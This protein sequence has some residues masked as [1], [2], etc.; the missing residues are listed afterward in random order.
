MGVDLQRYGLDAVSRGYNTYGEAQQYNAARRRG[1]IMKGI[2]LPVSLA[3]GAAAAPSIGS[4]WGGASAAASSAPAAT[5]GGTVAGQGFSIGRLL[6]SKGAQLVTGLGTTLLANR[7]AGKAQREANALSERTTNAQMALAR[8]QYDREN[9]NYSAD[10]ADA[11]RRWAAEE[12]FRAKQYAA[13][14]EERLHTRQ[15]ADEREAR[16]AP[17]RELSR[18]ALMRVGQILGWH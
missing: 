8:E 1:Q 18:Q 11:E 14:E 3:G 12:A 4:I 17:R 6:G 9:A 15:L 10:R 2:V 5:T 7:A 16:L 13:D